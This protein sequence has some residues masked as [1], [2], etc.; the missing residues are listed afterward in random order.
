MARAKSEWCDSEQPNTKCD[1][2]T[3]KN[4]G[5][6]Q[7][8]TSNPSPYSWVSPKLAL[9]K[10]LS[11]PRPDRHSWPSLAHRWREPYPNSQNLRHHIT[12]IHKIMFPN[13]TS[14]LCPI[15]RNGVPG[16]ERA[17]GE[18][19]GADAWTIRCRPQSRR[20]GRS[21]RRSWWRC[22]GCVFPYNLT[23]SL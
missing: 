6:Y 23:Q 7:W 13:T 1:K 12:P 17:L 15:S 5:V 16:L 2:K 14:Q 10:Y 8:L 9:D 4:L 3:P 22:G 20:P 18:K 19:S 11:K 21:T